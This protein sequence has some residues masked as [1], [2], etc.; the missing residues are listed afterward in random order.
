V[1]LDVLSSRFGTLNDMIVQRV[2]VLDAPDQLRGMIQQA[3]AANS[4]EDLA[5]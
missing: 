3:L 2:S 5:F 4:L 1:L